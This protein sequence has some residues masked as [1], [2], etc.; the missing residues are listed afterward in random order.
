MSVLINANRLISKLETLHDE[1]EKKI[2][3]TGYPGFE[4]SMDLIDK[5]EEMVQEMKNK[6][7][8]K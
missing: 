1:Y 8:K 6:G 3:E 5:I 4:S 2:D 7:Q